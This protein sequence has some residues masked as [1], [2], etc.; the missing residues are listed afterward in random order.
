MHALP[1]NTAPPYLMATERLLQLS[2]PD[3]RLLLQPSDLLHQLS[4]GFVLLGWRQ[5]LPHPCMSWSRVA[6]ADHDALVSDLVP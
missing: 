3:V 2:V 1:L 5:S 4:L 6:H